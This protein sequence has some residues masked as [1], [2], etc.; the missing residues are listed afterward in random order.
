[1]ARVVKAYRAGRFIAALFTVLGWLGLVITGC[2]LVVG[3]AIRS[4]GGDFAGVL[5]VMG[6]SLLAILLGEIG[7][8]V[9]DIAERHNDIGG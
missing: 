9:F 2:L 5:V 7:C 4:S 8:A 1:M 3:V 6:W